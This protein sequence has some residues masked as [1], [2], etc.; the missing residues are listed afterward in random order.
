MPSINTIQNYIK[1]RENIMVPNIKKPGFKPL[2]KPMPNKIKYVKP[3]IHTA[4]R[5]DYTKYKNNYFNKLS[6]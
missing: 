1:D 2:I 5:M 3:F 4:P 6:K